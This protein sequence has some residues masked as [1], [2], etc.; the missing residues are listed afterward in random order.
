MKSVYDSLLTQS[1]S[2]GEYKTEFELS[3][4]DASELEMMRG[5]ERR[6]VMLEAGLNPD[7]YDF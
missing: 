2:A 1:R 3:G 6:K 4:L 7:E 5:T